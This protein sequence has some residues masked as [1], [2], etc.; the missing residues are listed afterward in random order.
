MCRCQS[1]LKLSVD[2]CLL[3]KAAGLAAKLFNYQ[4]HCVSS[5]FCRFLRS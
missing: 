1:A 3:L 5:S 4:Q 2:R